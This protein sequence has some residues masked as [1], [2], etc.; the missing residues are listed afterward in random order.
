MPPLPDTSDESDVSF[1]EIPQ[2]NLTVHG[3]RPNH[4]IRCFRCLV[5]S[6]DG[7]GHSTPCTP[8][9]TISQLRDNILAVETVPMFK[10][11][12]ATSEGTLYYLM[13]GQFKEVDDGLKLFVAATD[14]LFTFQETEHN[15]IASYEAGFFNRF[16]FLFAILIE[17]RWRI[18]YRAVITNRHGLVV[19][20]LRSTMVIDNHKFI[21][22][23]SNKNTV[24]VFGIKPKGRCLNVH[25][26][27]FTN[28]DG[29]IHPKFRGYSGSLQWQNFLD[30][31]WSISEEL[32]SNTDLK[33]FHKRLYATQPEPVSTRQAQLL[34]T[35]I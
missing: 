17:G 12:I 6:F 11:N 24:M 20:K 32:D 8:L 34:E 14:G 31:T 26:N 33:W 5:T 3:D 2:R 29:I 21:L 10:F 22:P 18:R 19:F 9:N 15:T 27:V 1:V 7:S 30:E 13:G 16:S 25:L 35:N 4:Y 28:D 23:E